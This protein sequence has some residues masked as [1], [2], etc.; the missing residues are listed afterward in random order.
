MASADR[1]RND[2]LERRTSLSI[3]LLKPPE[4]ASW[5]QL[6]AEGELLTGG[7]EGKFVALPSQPRA[8]NWFIALRQYLANPDNVGLT[9]QA[10]A[11]LL[12]VERGDHSFAVTFGHAWQQLE[13]Q[14][15]VPDFG[16]R[17]ALNAVPPAKVLE[18][19]TEQVF[20]KWHLARE[21]SPRAAPFHEFGIDLDRDLVGAIE[22]VPSEA[23]FGGVVR[24]ST[25]LR[26][27]IP[28]HSLGAA[29][30]RA[31]ILYASDRYKKTWPEID[32]LAPVGDALEVAKLDDL[33]DQDLRSGKAKASAILFTPIVRNGEG[34]NAA[35][36][37]VF[38]RRTAGQP[39]APYLLYGSWTNYLS[40]SGK[41]PNLIHA[42]GTP[43]HM[44]D[45]SG[46]VFE[47]TSVYDCLGYEV[48]NGGTQCILSSGTWFEATH[49]FLRS[50]NQT[51]GRLA[52][53][54]IRLPS[55]DGVTNEEDYNRACCANGSGLMHFDRKIINFGG[56]QSKF[57]FCDFMHPKR[58]VLF[59][60]KILSRSSDCSHL[61]EQVRR[62]TQLLFSPDDAFRKR[63]R[64]AIRK[65]YPSSSTA[66][67]KSRPTVGSWSLC[68]VSLGPK[69]SDLPLFAKCGIARLVKELDNAGH[70]A[71]F[72]AV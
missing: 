67:L 17:V 52:T 56:G 69:L 62:T 27:T 41:T 1:R 6:F 15:L 44:F 68:L 70:P 57:E 35:S 47:T 16:R 19:S 32:N 14:W 39:I 34:N 63:L 20:A 28:M 45:E 53:P 72:L 55:W 9:G 13:T 5:D 23:I 66:W 26:M 10:P 24:G 59:F 46:D 12:L 38:G 49:D 3:Y 31:A 30:D 8:P 43:V 54:I 71:S 22:G 4:R 36:S 18:L 7:L 50:T 25:S 65:H 29:L 58:N 48:S 64:K 42:K 60:A 33:L 37:Y 2:P 11:G 40:R 61:V 51:L 21:R